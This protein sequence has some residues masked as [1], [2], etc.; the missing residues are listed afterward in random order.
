M[1][2]RIPILLCIVMTVVAAARPAAEPRSPEPV[3]EALRRLLTDEPQLVLDVLRR[4]PEE[5]FDIV[6]Q[7]VAAKQARAEAARIDQ[8]VEAPL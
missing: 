1:N 3:A 5:V 2:R 8:Q 6:R 7:G 4:H